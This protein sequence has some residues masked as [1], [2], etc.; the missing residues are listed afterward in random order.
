MR[1][2]GRAPLFDPDRLSEALCSLEGLSSDEARQ[3]AEFE[4]PDRFRALLGLTAGERRVLFYL[5]EGWAAQDIA[6]ELVVSLTTVRSHIRSVLRKLGVRSQLA[7]VAVANGR[8][9]ELR[10]PVGAPDWRRPVP[11]RRSGPVVPP[12]RSRPSSSYS[13]SSRCREALELGRVEGR[14][15]PR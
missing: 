11:G 9:L 3:I 10:H 13:G 15:G 7:A 14:A 8:D 5:T 6:D 2:P 1:G 4:F 12:T